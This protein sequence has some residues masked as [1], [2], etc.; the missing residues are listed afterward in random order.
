MRRGTTATGRWLGWLLLVA[1]LAA[2]GPTESDP[3]MEWTS[4]DETPCPRGSDAESC[5]VLR[6][7]T[8][9]TRDGSGLCEVHAIGDDGAHLST[10]ASFGPLALSP[11]MTFEWLVELPAADEP[12]FDGYLPECVATTSTGG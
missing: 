6:A 7:E 12:S 9:G 3:A 11:G 2:C 5:F 1:A 4:F 8:T 10:P